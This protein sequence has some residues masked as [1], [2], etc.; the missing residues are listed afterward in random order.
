MTDRKL[1][2]LKRWHHSLLTLNRGHFKAAARCESRNVNLGVPVTILSA[3]TG[4]T[5]FASLAISPT[6]WAKILVGLLSLTAAVLA[7]LQTFLRYD[8]RAQEHKEAGQ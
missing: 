1:L 5:I 4:T 6:V 3:V 2:I 8:E 7:S